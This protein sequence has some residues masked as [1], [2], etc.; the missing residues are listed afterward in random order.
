MNTNNLFFKCAVLLLAV[1]AAPLPGSAQISKTHSQQAS[2]KLGES[3]PRLIELDPVRVVATDHQNPSQLELD[4]K[5]PAQPIPAQDGAE[6]LRTIPGFSIIR[7]GGTD[8]DPV[9]RGMA[10]SRL[11]ILLDGEN[12][13]GG[14]GSRM[15]P[16]TAYV[17]PGAYDR[18]VLLRGPQSVRHGSGHSAG[19]V[20]FERE[21]TQFETPG[22]EGITQLTLGAF[23][24]NDQLLDVEAGNPQ[25][26]TRLS[27]TRTEAD[28]YE[29]GNGL[30]VPS[31]YE[32]WSAHASLGW[33]P[34]PAHR[35]ELSGIVSDGEAA[36]ADRAM[37]G[38]AFERENIG[39]KW[40]H[41]PT[42]TVNYAGL[43]A[44]VYYNYVD[45]VMDNFSLRNFLPTPM[46]PNPAISNPDRETIGARLGSDWNFANDLQL[47]I[48]L[49]SQQNEHRIRKTMNANALPLSGLSR[50]KDADF[51]Q[52]GAFTELE[53]P[54]GADGRWFAGGRLDHHRAQDLRDTI[55]V[56]M[57]GVANPTARE[58]RDDTL[59]SGFVRYE[60]KLSD[61]LL[62]SLGLGHAARLPDYWEL[63]N[64]E[65]P[66]S[67][68]A[69]GLEPEKTTQLDLGLSRN[70]GP[71]NYTLSV[72][73][74]QVED[75][76]LIESKIPKVGRTATIARNIETSSYG[77]EFAL[78]YD[79]SE[80]WHVDASLAYVRGRNRTD[81]RPL[82][83][84]PP[85]EG[86][87]ALSY[88]QSSWSVGGLLRLVDEQDRVAVNQGNIVGQD[89]GPSSGFAILSLNAAWHLSKQHR[90]TAGID[91]LFDKTYAEHLSRAGAVIPGF[92]PPDTRVNEPGR[93]AWVQWQFSF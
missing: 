10:G 31:A 28:D 66:N 14:C 53:G 50:Q 39:L 34:D 79:L 17:F 13:L 26:G 82:A 45:H 80:E 56:G 20:R 93:N 60:H 70:K 42:T 72:F 29:D 63:F 35:L 75:Y 57:A 6:I 16:P 46:M 5:S 44:H 91:N 51:K 61:S 3:T 30:K 77:G 18:V 86:R 74:N 36:Y 81:G 87:L 37:D 54:V 73:A 92:P 33:N 67:L 43:E 71:F 59:P 84:Q 85:L 62:L 47:H 25:W 21:P 23:G 88:T 8:G 7:K 83:Q 55:Q 69:F 4:P 19:T 41:T 89:I 65:S 1:S 52:Y 27:L 76:I 58:T 78:G 40:I 15:D 49:D 24:R 9:F 68:S 38:V 2:S 90:L 32:R 22:V 48:G 12:I 64:K 11:G